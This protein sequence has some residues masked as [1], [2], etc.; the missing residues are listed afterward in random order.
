KGSGNTAALAP[1]H[2]M[3]YLTKTPA[4]IDMHFAVDEDMEHEEI[5][6]DSGQA[7]EEYAVFEAKLF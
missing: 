6:D 4:L 2:R 7:S 3:V 1:K 5:V